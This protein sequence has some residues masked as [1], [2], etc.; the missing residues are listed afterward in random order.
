ME[1][2]A[3]ATRGS[4][5]GTTQQNAPWGLDRIDQET[6]TD[7]TYSY[8]NDG[9]GVTVYV[10]DTGVRHTHQEFDGR[11]S[12]GPAF[13]S[14]H[15]GYTS[16]DC[17][18]HGTNVAG[19]VGG[20]TYGVAKGVDIVS[21]RVVDC[22]SG[23]FSTDATDAVD[24]ITQYHSA[25]AVVNMSVSYEAD[26]A[27]DDAV[28]NSISAGITYVIAAGNQNS[29]ASNYSPSRVTE[30]IIVG[31][32]TSGDDRWLGGS[33]G[34]SNYGAGLDL[35]APGDQVPSAYH[36]S[37]T[38]THSY[39]GATSQAAPHVAGIAARYLGLYPNASPADVE[40][41][42]VGG[43]SQ[44]T[45]GNSVMGYPSPNLIA[46]SE[47][48]DDSP[49]PPPNTPSCSENDCLLTDD[50]LFAGWDLES[51]NMQ[52]LLSYQGDGNL[53]MYDASWNILWASNTNGYSTNRAVMQGDGNFVVY[54]GNWNAPWTSGT[55]CHDG[56]WLI[57]QNDGNLVIYN[58]NGDPVWDRFGYAESGCG[59]P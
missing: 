21:I 35:F 8:E 13:L 36:T 50:A 46:N 25:P 51:Q 5:A 15:P 23:G 3:Q 57:V 39:P 52:Y 31:A 29:L 11:A 24:Y 12:L 33:N 55:S 45:V 7:T 18:G 59:D 9:S 48:L 42:I 43:A 26:E 41:A 22:E 54:D 6:G 53:V 49:P 47:F 17:T 2:V 10:V 34:S 58:A 20:E 4:V 16:A 1:Y 44:V 56:A 37:D 40:E 38:A 14:E 30:A 19:I 32:T 27:L 28:R